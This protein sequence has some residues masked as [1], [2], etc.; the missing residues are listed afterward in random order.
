MIAVKNDYGLKN[1]PIIVTFGIAYG[2][3][4]N[5]LSYSIL[6]IKF[7]S[8]E[9]KPLFDGYANPTHTTGTLFNA[10]A[11]IIDSIYSDIVRIPLKP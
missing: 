4:L 10:I 9:A 5:K 2:S 3:S 7:V 1:L 11:S 8:H 6:L